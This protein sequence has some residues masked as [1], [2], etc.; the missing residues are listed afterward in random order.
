MA[1]EDASIGFH[2]ASKVLTALG[3]LGYAVVTLPD[4]AIPRADVTLRREHAQ[5][6]E[7]VLAILDEVA[8]RIGGADNRALAREAANKIRLMNAH[9]PPN[10]AP[11]PAERAGMDKKE[12]P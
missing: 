8:P 2:V 11:P 1:P 12:T 7:Y 9:L 3:A 10:A 5:S 4:P 6:I